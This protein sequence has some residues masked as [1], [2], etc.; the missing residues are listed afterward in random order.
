MNAYSFPEHVTISSEAKQ[1]I[2][3]ILVTDPKQRPTVDDIL[4][5]N[6]L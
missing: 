4:Q 6:F 1:L 5:H 2:K 3:N